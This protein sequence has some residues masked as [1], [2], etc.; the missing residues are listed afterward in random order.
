MNFLPGKRVG[1][2]D[3]RGR[4][5]ARSRFPAELRAVRARGDHRGRAARAP[6]AR[7]GRGP[8]VPLQ[9][10]DRRGARRRFA[11]ARRR[12]A[13][14]RWSRA[15]TGTRRPSPGAALDVLRARPGKLYFFDTAIGQAP[16]AM[17]PGCAAARGAE[18]QLLGAARPAPLRR[19]AAAHAA[20]QG[21]ARALGERGV[22]LDACRSTTRSPTA[23][24]STARRGLPALFRITPFVRARRRSTPSSSAAAT[25]AS[26]PRRWSRAPIAAGRCPATARR[27]DGARTRGSTPSASCAAR[28]PEHRHAHRARLQGMPLALRAVAVEQGGAVVATGLTIVEDDCAGLFDIVTHDGARR[29]GHARTV[30][31]SLL[32]TARELGARHAY[33]QVQADNEPAR[34]ALPRSSASRSA[35]CI[36]TAGGT[37]SG[38]DRG[39]P[40][41]RSPAALGPR[42]PAR[43]VV[44]SV[45]AESCTG[46]GVAAAITR[47]SG[48]R[49]VVRP[50]LRHLLQRRQAA[51][52]WAFAAQRSALRRGERG[53]GARDGAG[54]AAPQP[55][56]RERCGH[57]HRRPTGG[58]R[59]ASPSAWSGSPGRCAAAPC[60][61]TR[62]SLPGRAR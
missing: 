17:T 39:R 48:Q 52:C 10:R 27:A 61:P 24:A 25:G 4:R 28:P 15:S 19:L 43:K 34:R 23:S 20:R 59:A 22:S 3:R 7:R 29:Q 21:E 35:T 57:R 44:V 37:G 50:R 9:G 2:G 16:A 56:P 18:P 36:G 41:R 62:S 31:A 42:L 32:A 14:A 54:R 33:L 26:T 13:P 5:R 6:G 49:Q 1:D 45:T 55:L 46:G 30:V 12:S 8:G 40:H 51:S 60:R 53:G 47:I 38:N 11:G 58:A